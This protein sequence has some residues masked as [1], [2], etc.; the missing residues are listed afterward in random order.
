MINVCILLYPQ[1]PPLKTYSTGLYPAHTA[2]GSHI[3]VR[4]APQRYFGGTEDVPTR[5]IG[6]SGYHFTSGGGAYLGP[7]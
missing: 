3:F 6:A 4:Y 5:P 2:L 1:H 7:L